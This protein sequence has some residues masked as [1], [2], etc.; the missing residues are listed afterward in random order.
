MDK[1]V[2]KLPLNELYLFLILIFVLIITSWFSIGYYHPDEH[3]QLLEF[4][5]HKLFDCCIEDLPWEYAA[6]SRQAIQPFIVFCVGKIFT[7]FNVFNPF[8]LAFVLRLISVFLSLF[9]IKLLVNTFVEK[10]NRAYAY[11]I[12]STI[13]FFP[14][15]LVRFS[16]ENW[17]GS[18][19]FI[20][21]SLLYTYNA[22]S[23]ILKVLI[24][25]VILGFSFYC[26]FQI[27]FAIIPLMIWC[28][29]YVFKNEKLKFLLVGLG[30]IFSLLIGILIDFWFYQTWV[31]TPF[32]YFYSQVVVGVVNQFGTSPWWYYIALLCDSITPFFGSII[33]ILIC[34]YMVRN[35]KSIL[36]FV[37]LSFFLFHSFVGHK[38]IRFMFPMVYII[39]I[40]L[41]NSITYLLE[42]N[43][44]TFKNNYFVRIILMLVLVLNLIIQ[45][46]NNFKRYNSEIALMEF[47]YEKSR[48][49][50]I[51]V[52]SKL[53]YPF[54][55][56]QDIINYANK[57]IKINF[58][59]SQNTS[60]VQVA[61]LNEINFNN[62]YTKKSNV[63][64][65]VNEKMEKEFITKHNNYLIKISSTLP[66]WIKY[67]N[68]NNWQSRYTYFSIYRMK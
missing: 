67:F 57:S 19:F 60:L 63:Y 44:F 7:Y 52:C 12:Y 20:A 3:Y 23:S 49:E 15:L 10:E 36:T 31:F 28:F 54:I 29:F 53:G 48:S 25:G 32:N 14:F 50:I 61:E 2:F 27:A 9:A 16:S 41:L 58:Y 40:I 68:F 17:S 35:P 37:I 24:I 33:L 21:T 45:I 64:F 47:I 59:K 1:K 39:P 62:L 5:Y 4:G 43:L 56:K 46:V 55:D 30:F 38:E 51:T 66:D 34:I 6:K 18:L 26:R 8:F 11:L 22:R 42:I 13:F 65:L